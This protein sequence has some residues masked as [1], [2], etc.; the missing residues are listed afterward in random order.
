MTQFNLINFENFDNVLMGYKKDY[1]N[2]N[3][4]KDFMNVYIESNNLLR[5][6]SKERNIRLIDLDSMIPKKDSLFVDVIHLNNKGSILVSEI[7][8][9][10]LKDLIQ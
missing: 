8:T 10:Q 6:I 2:E 3:Q 7:I 4:I 5:K 1:L 9:N